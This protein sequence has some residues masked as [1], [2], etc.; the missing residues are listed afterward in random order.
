MLFVVRWIALIALL[1]CASGGDDGVVS[2][3]ASTDSRARDTAV[4]DTFYTPTDGPTDSIFPVDDTAPPKI[5]D[6]PVGT[7]ATASGA[8]MSSPG[9]SCDHNLGTIWNSGGYTG[10][11]KLTFPKPIYFDRV[12]I[13]AMSLPDCNETYTISAAGGSIGSG[14]RALNGSARWLDPIDVTPGTYGE[15]Q[16]DIAMADSWIT[17]AE[18]QVFDS[19]GGCKAP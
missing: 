13:A 10:W 1:G 18:V 9:D 15:I 3:D 14:T 11:M 17:L 5:C 12:R 6:T 19:T 4:V 8:Y 2:S 7:T 16:I